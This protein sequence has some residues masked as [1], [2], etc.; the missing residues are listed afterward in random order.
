MN[1]YTWTRSCTHK[2]LVSSY[3]GRPLPG[4]SHTDW[5]GLLVGFAVKC[6]TTENVRGMYD[7]DPLQSDSTG[8]IP[9]RKRDR[10]WCQTCVHETYGK[11]ISTNSTTPMDF[12]ASWSLTRTPAVH[13]LVDRTSAGRARV[14][15]NART[16][17]CDPHEDQA[18]GRTATAIAQSQMLAAR[19]QQPEAA[20][21]SSSCAQ[22][23]T[24]S[25]RTRLST[26]HGV[27]FSTSGPMMMPTTV[28]P[29][30]AGGESACK[31]DVEHEQHCIEE[32]CVGS[33]DVT[34][35]RDVRDKCDAR[36]LKCGIGDP[37]SVLTSL[38]Q[39]ILKIAGE[40]Y[41][42]QRFIDR[43][44]QLILCESTPSHHVH[45]VRELGGASRDLERGTSTL[46][47]CGVSVP[48]VHDI[49]SGLRR[50]CSS[51]TLCESRLCQG[52][53]L[54]ESRK[55]SFSNRLY[56]CCATAATIPGPR[57]SSVTRTLSP[58]L[59]VLS[60]H[61]V[62]QF[63]EAE[64]SLQEIEAHPKLARQCTVALVHA[65]LTS[66]PRRSLQEIEAYPQLVRQYAVA[67]VHAGRTLSR[68]CARRSQEAE[69][70]QQLLQLLHRE[71][72]PCRLLVAQKTHL[73]QKNPV[74]PTTIFGTSTNCTTICGSGNSKNCSTAPCALLS[75]VSPD[76]VEPCPGRKPH[77]HSPSPARARPGCSTHRPTSRP[78][79][80]HCART[81]TAGAST[82]F[83]SDKSPSQRHLDWSPKTIPSLNERMRAS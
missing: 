20:A 10:Q 3:V 51:G 13:E 30:V 43:K 49:C 37:E 65:G 32:L 68:H 63:H 67:L 62:L 9:W 69:L 5:F 55:P 56:G 40:E 42:L 45:I 11:P 60:W 80:A 81:G 73:H 66:P 78:G 83:R 46:G 21:A 39:A 58:R 34:I 29:S 35:V 48:T 54:C 18:P 50:P 36:R 61:S 33:T 59:Q 6:R 44:H 72:E 26:I 16:R 71:S 57:K 2:R 41:E 75:S 82:Y 77:R 28:D 52:T 15:D 70:H 7:A 64:L 53:L 24:P 25:A 38:H 22:T 8:P 23:P 79:S 17:G 1:E 27:S 12:S 74:S 14:E 19:L 4:T 31:R 47:G 76:S